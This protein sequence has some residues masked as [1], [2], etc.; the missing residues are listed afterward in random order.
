MRP[1]T[2]TSASC[3][4]A[5]HGTPGGAAIR[6]HLILVVDVFR[7]AP[8]SFFQIG[9]GG[10]TFV[11]IGARQPADLG[12]ATWRACGV[13]IAQIARRLTGA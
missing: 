7:A 9:I 12:T 4:S 6:R 3:G 13:A 8:H 2:G 5:T 11:D 10:G 1:P